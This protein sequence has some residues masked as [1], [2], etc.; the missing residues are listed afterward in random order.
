M[1]I[2]IVEDEVPAR[3]QLISLLIQTATPI[4]V[5]FETQ[6]VKDTVEKLSTSPFPDLIFMDIQLN[7]G[8][9][10]EIFR[11][12]NVRCP[13]IFTTA[14]DQYMLEAFH[15]NGIDYLLKPI[16]K[17]DLERAL[18]KFS[19]L[20]TH[21]SSD[22]Q[23]NLLRFGDRREMYKK[24]FLVRK[25]IHFRSI[26]V[27]EVGYFFSE[28]KVTFLVSTDGSQYIFEKP[29]A[30]LQAELDPELFFRINRR[31]LASH[32]AIVSFRSFEK[33]KLLVNLI[34]APK[35]EVL[36]SQEKAALFKDWA[37]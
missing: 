32:P 21:F 36:V 8:L 30:E 7:D 11:Q 18:K 9:S 2:A 34:P 13:V 20:R 16:K 3:K 23:M 6:S 35:E 33:G 26:P 22:Q 19:D 24:R 29:L 37:G 5:L 31:Y 14:Y 15:E 12:V 4:D 27:E 28:H 1:N 25:G 17:G 10:F